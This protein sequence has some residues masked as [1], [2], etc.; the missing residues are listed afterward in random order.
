MEFLVRSEALPRRPHHRRADRRLSAHGDS[1]GRVDELRRARRAGAA[2]SRSRSDLPR[3][4]RRQPGGE[5]QPGAGRCVDLRDRRLRRRQ[6]SAQGR[7]G[8]DALRSA[9]HQQDRSRAARRR[10][11]RGHGARREGGAR[12][13]AVRLHQPEDRRRRRRTSS[14]GSS[15]SCCSIDE[16]EREPTTA[17]RR[18]R[19]AGTRGSSSSSACATDARCWRTPMPSRRCGSAAASRRA[20]ALHLILASSAPGIFGGDR[21]EQ[22]DPPRARRAVRLTSQS[23][24]QVHPSPDGPSRDAASRRSTSAKRRSCV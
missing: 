24:L 4:R 22:H 15:A 7:A 20:T 18:P 21:F 2:P 13:A 3:E 1:R 9:R 12:R 6:D 5:L 23:A 11:P 17:S 19:S 14:R 10:Q 16:R 8:R